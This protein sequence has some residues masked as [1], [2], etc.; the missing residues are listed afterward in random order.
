M[1][2]A[3]NT[4]RDDDDGWLADGIIEATREGAKWANLKWRPP[5]ECDAPSEEELEALA[6]LSADVFSL[7]VVH[8]DVPLWHT[9]YQQA[10]LSA[11]KR[12]RAALVRERERLRK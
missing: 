6:G 4:T 12:Q 7:T 11:F 10:F 5:D 8:H 3:M 2:T 1:Y 9:T